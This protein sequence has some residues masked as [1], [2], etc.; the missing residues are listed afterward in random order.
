MD[1]K[2]IEQLVDRYF[3]CETTLQEEQILRT[4]FAQD[5]D[6]MPQELRRYRL[7]FEA[8]TPEEHLSDEFTDR[9]LAMT[10]GKT[11]STVRIVSIAERLRPLLR[12]VAIVAVILALGQAIDFSTS[13]SSQQSD[14]INYAN[15]KDTYD[16]PS[17]AYDKVEDALQLM[18]E[19]FNQA[20]STDSLMSVLIPQTDSIAIN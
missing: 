15:Y 6:K 14:D 1:Y 16:D 19:G 17:V 12:A 3:E 7:V 18:S 5:E 8:L 9:V 13:R 2:Y 20:R 10:E 4:F 11:A